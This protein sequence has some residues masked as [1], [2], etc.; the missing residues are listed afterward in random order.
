MGE[1]SRICRGIVLTLLNLPAM[2][3]PG[4]GNWN[5]APDDAE[6]ESLACCKEENM[7]Q[8]DSNW[9]L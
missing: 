2:L 1:T 6:R 5:R 9:T 3:T 8:I 4:N 7:L